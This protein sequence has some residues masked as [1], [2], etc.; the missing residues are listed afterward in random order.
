MIEHKDGEQTKQFF[1]THVNQLFGKAKNWL[2][3]EKWQVKSGETR[4]NEEITGIYTAPTLLINAPNGEELAEIIPKGACIIEAKGRIDIEGFFGIE[5]IGYF[6][7][8][9][10][11]LSE[12]RQLYKDVHEDGWYWVANTREPKAGVITKDLLLK[13]IKSVS[14]YER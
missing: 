11:L 6:I 1:L 10:P 4:I 14:D 9:G 7:N 5:H 13:L 2:A 12:A 3:E 8:G